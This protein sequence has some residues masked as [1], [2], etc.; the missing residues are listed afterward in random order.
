MF[1]FD[2]YPEF[3]IRQKDKW[4]FSRDHISKLF[5]IFMCKNFFFENS[6]SKKKLFFVECSKKK[7]PERIRI[8]LNTV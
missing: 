5:E 1:H 2:V 3:F 7:D 4:S 8:I 6:Y